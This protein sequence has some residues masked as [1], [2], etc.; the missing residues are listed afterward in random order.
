MSGGSTWGEGVP[1]AIAAEVDV[2]S[3]EPRTTGTPRMRS[4]PQRFIESWVDAFLGFLFCVVLPIPLYATDEPFVG[5]FDASE[6][7]IVTTAI[8]YAIVWYCGRRLNAFP[9]A[10]L[11]AAH[12]APVA[13]ITYALIAAI[14]LLLRL[15]YSRVQLFGSGF[16]TVLWMAAIA[17][18]RG[19]YLIRQLP[20]CRGFRPAGGS[21][22]TM[23][24]SGA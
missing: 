23:C 16:L 14:L 13:V 22:S 9:G 1:R 19:R 6:L 24:A 20:P 11:N 18:L 17:Q 12:V 7:T 10:G 8:A 4:A 15:D 3:D 2:S 21:I 5:P